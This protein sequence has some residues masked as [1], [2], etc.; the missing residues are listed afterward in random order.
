MEKIAE[1]IKRSGKELEDISEESGITLSNLSR[2]LHGGNPTAETIQKIVDVTGQPIVFTPKR[3]IPSSSLFRSKKAWI[4]TATAG[5]HIVLSKT[6]ALEYLGL[7]QGYL[8]EDEITGYMNDDP[9]ISGLTVSTRPIRKT[10]INGKCTTFERTVNDIL[11]SDDDRQPLIEALSEWLITGHKEPYINK[12]NRKE[13]EEIK[14][15]AEEY[16]DEG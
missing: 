11:S 9:E 13:Y 7:F 12:E 2:Y 4:D 3:K 1:A 5:I 14:Q 15:A 16:Y 6:S 8:Y 10:E